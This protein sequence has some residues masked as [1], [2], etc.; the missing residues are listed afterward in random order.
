MK[1][2]G[3]RLE[4]IEGIAWSQTAFVVVCLFF[5]CVVS[6]LS[7]MKEKKDYCV[8]VVFETKDLREN[9]IPYISLCSSWRTP[10]GFFLFHSS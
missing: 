4:V 2:V 6:S 5:V 10:G 8:G 3:A 9:N 1:L 7:N